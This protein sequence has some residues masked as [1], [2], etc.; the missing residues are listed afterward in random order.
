METKRNCTFVPAGNLSDVCSGT[1]SG[2]VGSGFVRQVRGG[3]GFRGAGRQVAGCVRAVP[4]RHVRRRGGTG[5]MLRV[6]ERALP[7]RNG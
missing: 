7:E 2:G 4:R 3:N 5:A 6:P 1:L